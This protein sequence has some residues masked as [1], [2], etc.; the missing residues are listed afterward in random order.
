[1]KYRI[2][3]D[4]GATEIIEAADMEA[5]MAWAKEWAAGGEYEQRVMVDVDVRGIDEEGEETDEHEWAE[6]EAGPE[7]EAPE[8]AEGEEHEW[9]YPHAIVGGLEEDPG[10]WSLG[11]TADRYHSVCRHCGTHRHETHYGSQ[12][13]PGQVDTVTYEAPDEE[14]LAWVANQAVPA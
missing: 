12:R 1:M 11:G 5:A 13:N 2:S 10:V 8:C 14:T 6:V 9:A 3:E 4:S 7:P